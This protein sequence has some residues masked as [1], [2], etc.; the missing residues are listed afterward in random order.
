LAGNINNIEA[1]CVN[2]DCVDG[3]ATTVVGGQGG[4]LC[5]LM[6]KSHVT[7]E[8]TWKKRALAGRVK[9]EIGEYDDE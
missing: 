1:Y 9:K 4:G 8:M 3:P 6:A 2:R 7:S 5:W